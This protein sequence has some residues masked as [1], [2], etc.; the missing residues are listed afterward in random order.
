[1]RNLDKNNRQKAL[2]NY[3]MQKDEM[4]LTTGGDYNDQNAAKYKIVCSCI[5]S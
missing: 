5:R 4:R 3:E 1:M 2:Q